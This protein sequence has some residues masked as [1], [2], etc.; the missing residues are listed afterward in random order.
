MK[1]KS[2]KN[3]YLS[4]APLLHKESMSENGNYLPSTTLPMNTSRLKVQLFI[5]CQNLVNVDYVG[6]TDSLVALYTKSD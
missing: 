2:S 4:S 5:S 1:K 6:K 3:Q